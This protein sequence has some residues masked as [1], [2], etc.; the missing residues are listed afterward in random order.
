MASP[1]AK[2]FCLHCEKSSSKPLRN[3]WDLSTGKFAQLCKRCYSIYESGRFCETFHKQEHDWR[4][5]E[6][7]SKPVHCSC[8]V[9]FSEWCLLEGG[10]QQMICMEC[11][12][13]TSYM[14]RNFSNV[15]DVA[16][17]IKTLRICRIPKSAI[18]PMFE[19]LLTAADIDNK[20]GGI[21]I[22][23]KHAEAYLPDVSDHDG[24]QLY[25]FDDKDIKEWY[26]RLRFWL[27]KMYVLDGLREYMLS[28][29]LQRGDTLIFSR[30]I[31]EGP[32]VMG[33]TKA[34]TKKPSLKASNRRRK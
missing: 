32:Y 25:V 22:P 31:P 20:D 30:V 23:K 12:N 8:L 16:D 7:C 19:K 6:Y 10:G 33:F 17:G 14:A 18:V 4:R 11:S 9:S 5:C 24:I 27:N 21:V 34:P 15:M 2:R 29:K 3:G 26:P 28:H 13:M 1:S